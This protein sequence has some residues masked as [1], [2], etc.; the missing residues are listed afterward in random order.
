MMKVNF[1]IS[2]QQ[3]LGES[4]SK[5]LI[6]WKFIIACVDYISNWHVLFIIINIVIIVQD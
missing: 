4:D 6:I 3:Y 2:V 1:K 5:V